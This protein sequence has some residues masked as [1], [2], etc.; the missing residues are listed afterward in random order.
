MILHSQQGTALS[1]GQRRQI[2]MRAQ[3]SSA[4]A[5]TGNVMRDLENA[6]RDTDW[7]SVRYWNMADNFKR[8]GFCEFKSK[9][10]PFVG[11]CFGYDENPL[12]GEPSSTSQGDQGP[13]TQE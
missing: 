4:I 13:N 5:L 11:D 7:E 1:A 9:G 12:L 10:T 6:Y 8:F 3:V 2:A